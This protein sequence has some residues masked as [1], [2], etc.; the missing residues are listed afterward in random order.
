MWRPFFFTLASS[1]AVVSAQAATHIVDLAWSGDGRFEHTAGVEAGK[2]IEVC[3]RLERGQ[4]VQWH[5][6]ASAPMDFNIHYHVGKD[7]V[8][9]TKQ[10][11]VMDAQDTLRVGTA[12]VYCWMWT[13]KS[14][15]RATVTVRLQR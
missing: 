2:F 7:T 10:P 6:A 3:G 14:G 4:A 15:E 9:P 12:E 1:A 5:F 13:N 8:F 11:Q